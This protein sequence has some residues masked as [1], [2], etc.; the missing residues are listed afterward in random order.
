MTAGDDGRGGS[1]PQGG[2]LLRFAEAVVARDQPALV[3]ARAELASALG[4]AGLIDAAAVAGL[5]NAI[6]RVA[7]ATG[8]PL[9]QWKADDTADFRG[10]I[11]IDRF[12][13][14]GEKG[15]ARQ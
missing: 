13:A 12:A 9:E 11:G 7:D 14:A 8:I 4:G 10:A 1:V 3:D 6:D 5:F 15:G 2:P